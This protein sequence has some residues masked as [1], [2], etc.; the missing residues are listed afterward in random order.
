L[1]DCFSHFSISLAIVGVAG[2]C[3]GRNDGPLNRTKI[4]R[5]EKKDKKRRERKEKR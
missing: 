1:A 4:E 2:L 5:K 3:I